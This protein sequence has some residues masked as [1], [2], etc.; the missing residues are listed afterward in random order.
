M[1]YQ[2]LTRLYHEVHLPYAPGKPATAGVAESVG[3]VFA[4]PLYQIKLGSSGAY[5]VTLGE[6]K[7]T[8]RIP[9]NR[10]RLTVGAFSRDEYNLPSGWMFDAHSSYSK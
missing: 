2:D 1:I 5:I 6:A 10:E 4:T 7:R 9:L 3:D 8:T